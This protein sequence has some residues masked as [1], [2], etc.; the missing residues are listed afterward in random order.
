MEVEL[1]IIQQLCLKMLQKK[2]MQHILTQ[3]KRVLM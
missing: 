1:Y 2:E 3:Q